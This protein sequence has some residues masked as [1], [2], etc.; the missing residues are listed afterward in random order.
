L[1]ENGPLE[2]GDRT[3]AAIEEKKTGPDGIVVFEI[4]AIAEYS[5]D[6]C[7]V[8]EKTYRQS[9]V[10]SVPPGQGIVKLL[11]KLPNSP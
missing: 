2:L 11:I 10:L 7:W 1:I 8:G 3:V 4:W 5:I 6:A 9:K